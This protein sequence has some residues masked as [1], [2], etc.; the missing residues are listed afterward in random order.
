MSA[1]TVPRVHETLTGVRVG[2]NGQG[3]NT[4]RA[5]VVEGGR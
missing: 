4:C 5:R 2:R 3:A 1:T